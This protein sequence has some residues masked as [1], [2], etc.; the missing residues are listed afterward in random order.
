ML[1]FDVKK[2]LVP[3]YSTV[4]QEKKPSLHPETQSQ[5]PVDFPLKDDIDKQECETFPRGHPRSQ[6]PSRLCPSEGDAIVMSLGHIL[7]WEDGTFFKLL[8]KLSKI[9]WTIVSPDSN[10]A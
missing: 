10:L 6:T 9:V 5:P 1:P 7:I 2:V 8:N 3:Y 4:L